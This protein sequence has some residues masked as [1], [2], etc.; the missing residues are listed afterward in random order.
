MQHACVYSC[1]HVC[2]RAA[3]AAA[4]FPSRTCGSTLSV[5]V[6]LREPKETGWGAGS[7]AEPAPP[8]CAR[9]KEG[10]EEAVCGK[11]RPVASGFPKTEVSQ[12][13]LHQ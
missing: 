2:T 8:S 1:S 7:E 9:L 13:T 10:G 3:A 11:P 12:V 6:M 5:R 4:P